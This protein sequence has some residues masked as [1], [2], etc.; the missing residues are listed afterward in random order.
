MRT[1]ALWVY[2]QGGLSSVIQFTAGIILAR[3][4]EPSDF[5]V[6]YAVTAYTSLLMLQTRFGIPS[7]LIQAKDLSAAQWN[8]A[9]W[10]MQGIALFCILLIFAL[11]N[12]LQGFYDD[13]RFTIIMW[14]M[15]ITLALS[16]IST[17]SNTL[18]RRQM[19][20][21]TTSRVEIIVG[22]FAVFV[23]ISCAIAGF[24]PFSFVIAGV[25]SGILSAILLTRKTSW[26]P[27]FSLDMRGLGSILSYGWRLHLNS[28]LNMGA[29]KADNMLIG[30]LSGVAALGIYNR[31]LSSARMPV[32]EITTRLYQLF[33]SG[34][35]RIQNDMEHTI[36]MY[37]KVLC[38]MSNAVFPFLLVFIFAA[39]SFIYFIYGEK[40]LPAA[41]PLQIL[42]FGSMARVISITMG[43]LADAQR[44]AKKETPIQA[45][46]LAAT[47]AAVLIGSRWGL[48]GI[49]TGIAIKSI[50]LMLL[51]HFMLSHSHVNLK[52]RILMEGINPAITA[53]IVASAAALLTG[54]IL[55]KNH[56]PTGIISL[57]I[58]T[59]IIFLSYGATLIAYTRLVPGN[60][61]LAANITMFQ[62]FLLK[63]RNKIR[64]H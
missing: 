35:A 10:F 24:G 64:I 25:F 18:L 39:E 27:N 34:L 37:V 32:T 61:A 56:M 6:F 48:T 58:V 52:W 55:E 5:G 9:F 19:D 21:K 43:A 44:L 38:A 11:S 1:G 47:I 63:V 20:Y 46:N 41:E 3:I 40:W 12:W 8:T 7:A 13:D 22:L 29:N 50:L 53:S 51:M 14:F 30:S 23:S 62:E 59:S 60:E 16:P 15:A 42:A 28:T 33:F 17:I 4:L 57:G 2:L 45:F 49:A 36:Q 31:A 26:R 54:N